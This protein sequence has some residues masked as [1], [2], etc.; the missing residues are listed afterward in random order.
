MGDHRGGASALHA[1]V[2]GIVQGVGFRYSACREAR[3]LGLRGWVRNL[4]D[5]DVELLAEGEEDALD[6]F[7]E[8]LRV[9]PDGARIRSIRTEILAPTG[10]YVE[11]TIE[12]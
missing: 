5:G 10:Y 6:E 8:W 12:Y 2:S 3:R 1:I 7:R 11:F 9:G 4:G